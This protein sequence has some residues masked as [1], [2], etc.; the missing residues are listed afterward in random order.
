MKPRSAKNKGKLLQNHVKKL[1]VEAFPELDGHIKSTTMGESGEDIQLSPTARNTI[2]YQ[3]ECKS[4]AS[5]AVY[6]DFSQAQNHGRETPCLII[7][8]NAS[9]PLA[10]IDLEKFIQLIRIENDYRKSVS[11]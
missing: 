8:Q 2:P 10:V 5:I 9:K 11:I 1:L 7:K 4:R 6:R 3:F